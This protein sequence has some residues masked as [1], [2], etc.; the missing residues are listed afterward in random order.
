MTEKRIE[1]DI[2]ST[3]QLFDEA[4]PSSRYHAT[5]IV[6]VAGEDLGTGLLVHYLRQ[7]GWTAE[8]LVG[9]CTQGTNKGVRLDRW[10]RTIRNQEIVYYQTEIK[11]WS[12]HAIGGK[13]LKISVS[14]DELAAHKI[15]RWGKEWDGS[16]FRKKEAKK[17]LAPMKSLEQNCKV[18]P[19]ICYWDA[20]H[21]TGEREPLFDVALENSHFS[22]VWV[23]SMSAYLRELLS[24]GKNKIVLEMP[25]TIKRVQWLNHLFKVL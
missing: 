16:T 1:V 22:R 5:A 14:S 12:A 25:D 8:V 20:M 15:E 2:R 19:L 24:S 3:L 9:P 21:P 17:V 4:I 11:N 7:Q 10:I 13:V 6:A 23:F 18:E